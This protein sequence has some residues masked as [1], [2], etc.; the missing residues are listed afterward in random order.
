MLTIACLLKS[1][2]EFKAE[3]VARLKQQ[4]AKIP[5]E[6][7]VCLSDVKVPCERIPLVHNWPRWW[8]QCELFRRD[9]FDGPV[10]Y[11]D[12]DT[13]IIKDPGL[14]IE[15]NDFW[16]L[17]WDGAT[18]QHAMEPTSGVMAWWGDFSHIY[19][20]CK[21]LTMRPAMWVNEG[22]FPFQPAQFIQE[23]FPGFY[24]YKRDVRHKGLPADATV[25][26]F[27]GTPRPWDI[28][29]IAA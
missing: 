8:G 7:F 11:M 16:A 22:I 20:K 1:G 17:G 15:P 5:Y 26:Y 21:V 3:H 24:S 10:L 23:R 28:P 2:G 13:T 29:E 9:L 25:V 12:L 14:V 19:E 18:H 4:C 6:R 27:H